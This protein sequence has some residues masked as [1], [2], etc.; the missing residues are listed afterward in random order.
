MSFFFGGIIMFGIYDLNTCS[1]LNYKERLE[2]YKKC[3]FKEIALYIDSSYQTNNEN[4]I[5]IINYAK[6]INLSINQAH[7]DWKISNLICDETTNKYFDYISQKS[8]ILLHMLHNQITH[9]L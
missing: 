3:G 8:N 9:Q 2:I 7:L 5:E 6:K 1:S 4:Y